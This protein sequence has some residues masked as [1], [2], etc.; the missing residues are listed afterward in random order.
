ML[1]SALLINILRRFQL[2]KQP[3][4]TTQ[5]L[6]CSLSTAEG[7]IN[8]L[9]SGGNRSPAFHSPSA[10]PLPPL[11]RTPR[12]S[13]PSAAMFSAGGINYMPAQLQRDRS[14]HCHIRDGRGLGTQSGPVYFL[15]S[16]SAPISWG[17]VCLCSYLWAYPA[18]STPV[19]GPHG[20][21][22]FVCSLLFRQKLMSFPQE[23]HWPD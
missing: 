4:G 13:Q 8:G 18:P 23:L 20:S 19:S 5:G 21:V 11:S 22:A 16:P 1:G 2:P 10:L 17:T 7:L 14:L 15:S 3:P 6:S 12:A 9:L